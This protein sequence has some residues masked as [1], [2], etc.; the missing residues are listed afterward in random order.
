MSLGIDLW[1]V[2]AQRRAIIVSVRRSI[3]L[4]FP[5]HAT[6]YPRFSRKDVAHFTTHWGEF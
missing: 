1:I 6:A 5:P 4:L 2:D 3:P